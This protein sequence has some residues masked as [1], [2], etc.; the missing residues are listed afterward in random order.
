MKRLLACL[1]ILTAVF[2]AA[3][4]H[5]QTA[6]APREVAGIALGADV[7]DLASRLDLTKA[8]PLWDKPYLTRAN[9]QPTKGFRSGYVLFGNCANPGRVVRVKLKYADKDPSFFRNTGR[10]LTSRYGD[11]KPLMSDQGSL[12]LGMAWKFGTLKTGV[13][14]L[15]LEH[16]AGDDPEDTEGTSIRLT[17]NSMLSLEQECYEKTRQKEPH[18]QPS[19]PLFEIT[20]DWLLPK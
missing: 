13:T 20:E 6:A 15:L 11:P 14:A 5:A 1:V 2:A 9:I 4:A 19:F 16:A 12:Y 17:D 7:K 8:V 10:T 18:V 3:A